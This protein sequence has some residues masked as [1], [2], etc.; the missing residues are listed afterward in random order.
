ML[1]LG[2]SLGYVNACERV[3]RSTLPGTGVGLT[4]VP[5]GKPGLTVVHTEHFKSQGSLITDWQSG[6]KHKRGRYGLAARRAVAAAFGRLMHTV[7][8]RHVPPLP[9]TPYQRRAE[10][11]R[12][13]CLPPAD[14]ARP[15]F[16]ALPQD[17]EIARRRLRLRAGG[18]RPAHHRPPL[19]HRR[20]GIPDDSPMRP[21][22]TDAYDW[23]E[24]RRVEVASAH[25]HRPDRGGARAGARGR[26]QC[27]GGPVR[28]GRC[29]S[30]RRRS[31]GPV[32]PRSPVWM[33][34]QS[35]PFGVPEEL[36]V[37]DLLAADEDAL[38]ALCAHIP[39]EAA[40]ALV[41]YA[42][43]RHAPGPARAEAG[44]RS[45]PAARRPAP[46]PGGQF[47]RGFGRAHPCSRVPVGPLDPLPCTRARNAWW[48]A[49]SMAPA[50]VAGSAG[51]GKT[52]VALHRAARL[53]RALIPRT[54]YCS[55]PSP[56]RSPR[57]AQAQA[58][59]AAE[60]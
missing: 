47:R 49:R 21:I 54:V 48:S 4:S 18:T 27:D 53:L 16:A 52:V 26:A 30:P 20:A 35:C 1:G 41:A 19:A 7:I 39:A 10:A 31:I 40:E 60:R 12:A 9:R 56:S 51:T 46:V 42:A 58:C 28:A 43:E 24:R 38:L 37:S 14:G 29:H 22:T 55:P 44:R 17:R 57:N 34:T 32:R 11:K 6:T 59:P 2:T 15:P 23:A 33:P 5:Y 25:P 45:V 50:R 13:D 8:C 36:G 3:L